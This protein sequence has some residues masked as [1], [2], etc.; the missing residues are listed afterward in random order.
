[1]T[2]ILRDVR[3][4]AGMGRVYLPDEDL[5]RFGVEPALLRGREPNDAF[6]RLMEFEVKRAQEYYAEAAPLVGLVDARS[7]G[8]LWALIQI[9]HRLLER[10]EQARFDVLR[11][12]VR[13]PTWEK[14]LFLLKGR[15]RD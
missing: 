13:V 3:E 14:V 4:D 2:N 12:R 8:S 10:I 9:Y 11:Q 1:L 6:R 15:L 7:S 5:V